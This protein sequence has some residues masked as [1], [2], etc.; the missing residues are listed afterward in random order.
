MCYSQCAALLRPEGPKFEAES[1]ERGRG[2]W[3]RECWPRM[4]FGRIKSPENSST[5]YKCR[6]IVVNRR[7]VNHV[8]NFLAAEISVT[9]HFGR[10]PIHPVHVLQISSS[11]SRLF[12]SSFLLF[13]CRSV[14]KMTNLF[15]HCYLFIEKYVQ[16]LTNALYMSLSFNKNLYW[17]YTA[18][19]HTS[20]TYKFHCCQC[21]VVFTD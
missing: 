7:V 1:R 15:R 10:A 18:K 3:R 14:T 5:D 12:C 17:P 16:E 6:L 13:L 2:S 11:A 21:V 8:H 20:S 19:G 4:H 9:T